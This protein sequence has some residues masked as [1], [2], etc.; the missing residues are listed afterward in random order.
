MTAVMRCR[1]QLQSYI[2]A[3]IQRTA[4]VTAAIAK[5]KGEPEPE[6]TAS[7]VAARLDA[8]ALLEN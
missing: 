4:T 8:A 7:G 1:D 6:G 5:L 2:S 3:Q